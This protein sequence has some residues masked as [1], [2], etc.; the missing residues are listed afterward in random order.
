[1]GGS[2][3]LS[4]RRSGLCEPASNPEVFGVNFQPSCALAKWRNSFGVVGAGLSNH[5]RLPLETFPFDIAV[6]R[7]KFSSMLELEEARERILSVIPTLGTELTASSAALGRIATER[8]DAPIDLPGFDNS[9]MDG[10]AV[11]A[12]DLKNAR[13]DFPISLRRC[14]ES[15]AGE[16]FSGVVEAGTCVRVFTGSA[17]PGGAD[18]VVMQE[19]TQAVEPTGE[20]LFKE[21]IKPWENVR[22]RG[23]D[24]KQGT[25]LLAPGES[26][27]IGAVSLLTALGVGEVHVSRQPV[28]G[29]LSTGSELLEAGQPV[30]PGK[31]Y[32][33]NR[34]TLAPLIAAAGA[35]PKV[36][37]LVPD[38]LAATRAA[39]EK[40]FSETDGVVTTGGVSVGEHDLVKQ[41]FEQLGGT[42]EFWKVAIRPGKPFVF[43]RYRDRVLFG[44]PGNP[45]SALVTFLLLVRPA[46][47]RWQGASHVDL[48]ASPGILVEPLMNQGDRRHFVRVTIDATGNV[49]SSG[50]Q[51][52]H[53]LSSLMK[54][55]GLVD[56]A[57]Q[58][59]L[60]AGAIVQ[61]LRWGC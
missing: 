17:L 41:A 48:P 58:S 23:E 59:T 24:V 5:L 4:Y 28:I 37:P 61:V 55:N 33:S 19:D 46:L 57:P 36:F 3:G 39:L 16:V 30:T 54:A 49:R 15:A 35:R 40:A 60:S 11:R 38:N 32:E 31:I 2:I 53:V 9:A 42:M 56:V 1:M 18:A 27:S 25:P 29:L 13:N 52:S 6:D 10:Y 8:L 47:L 45:I 7:F 12:A 34:V 44:L 50:V 43:G 20:I 51:A 14:G 22:L 26:L 21:S